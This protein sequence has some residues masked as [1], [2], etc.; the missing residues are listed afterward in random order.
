MQMVIYFVSLKFKSLLLTFVPFFKI[1]IYKTKV[2]HIAEMN[3]HIF[4][5]SV[6]KDFHLDFNV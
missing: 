1:F 5:F 3:E 2:L 6:L 4:F